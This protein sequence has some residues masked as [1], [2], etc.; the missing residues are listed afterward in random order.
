[1]ALEITR[2]VR[3]ASLSTSKIWSTTNTTTSRTDTVVSTLSLFA[4]SCTKAN[5]FLVLEGGANMH[6]EMD[7]RKGSRAMGKGMT[8]G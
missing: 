1:M 5:L 4:N 7:Y 6:P 3:F 2:M 8:D